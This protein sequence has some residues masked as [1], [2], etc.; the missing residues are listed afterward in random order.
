MAVDL[1]KLSLWLAT[2][3]KDHPFTFLDHALRHGDS[4]VG[5]SKKQI[6]AFHWDLTQAAQD[7]RFGRVG[8]ALEE[9]AGPLAQNSG[10]VPE[11]NPFSVLKKREE[12]ALSEVALSLVRQ[13]GDAAIAAFFNSRKDAERKDNRQDILV[14]L[15]EAA[16]RA[17]RGGGDEVAEGLGDDLGDRRRSAFPLS[18]FHWEIEFPEVFERE[19]PVFDAMVGNQPFMGGSKLSTSAGKVFMACSP[20]IFL[21]PT[22]KATSLRTSSEAFTRIRT[23]GTFGLISTNTIRQGDTR[24]T[25]LRWIRR[26]Q[27]LFDIY[28]RRS[29]EM[30][31]LGGG[32]CQ[33][34]ACIQ[35]KPDSTVR[36]KW[37][38]RSGDY[39]HAIR[40]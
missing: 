18:P 21:S 28:R 12:L 30:A 16:C 9:R 34:C 37:Q 4:L 6:L 11:D 8:R 23:N 2:L 32:R 5:L 38:N 15:S 10:Q 1:A 29:Q 7:V 19:N 36:L 39:L 40:N 26:A 25:G 27:K 24:Q 13:V 31:W 17:G 35:T 3:A 14:M 33:C 22:E 20:I